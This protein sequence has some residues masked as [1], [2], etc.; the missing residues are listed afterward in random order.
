MAEHDQEFAV[1]RSEVRADLKAI[2]V[3]IEG[4]H[5]QLDAVVQ[6]RD[7]LTRMNAQY[8]NWLSEKETMWGKLDKARED[9]ERIDQQLKKDEGA[10]NFARWLFGLVS[11]GLISGLGYVANGI[12]EL[13]V[14][15]EKVR[16][17]ESHDHIHQK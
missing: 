6:M 3:S 14:M 13:K 10:S 9:I 2:G 15:Q 8:Q 16:V 5:K 17:L 11:V 4:I 1:F 7:E 12:T